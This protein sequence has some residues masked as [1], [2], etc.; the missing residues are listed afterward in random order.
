MNNVRSS[1]DVITKFLNGQEGFNSNKSLSSTGT[2]LFSYD[3]AI[4]QW[5]MGFLY[6]NTTKY[7]QTT[8][9]HANLLKACA[10][11]RMESKFIIELSHEYDLG[12]KVLIP[13]EVFNG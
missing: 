8:T 5:D 4:A 7:S 10:N 1:S 2:T 12:T 9:S 3:T 6:L 13:D 11:Q